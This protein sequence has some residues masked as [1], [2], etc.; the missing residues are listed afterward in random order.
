MAWRTHK[1]YE[2]VVV[3]LRVILNSLDAGYYVSKFRIEEAKRALKKLDETGYSGKKKESDKNKPFKVNYLIEL[4]CEK[5]KN[6]K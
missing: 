1:D 3:N 4:A 5:A 2:S 6:S